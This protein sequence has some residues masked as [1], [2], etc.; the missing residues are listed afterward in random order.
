MAGLECNMIKLKDILK[1]ESE[2]SSY[3]NKAEQG[4][5]RSLKSAKEYTKVKADG[6]T[7]SKAIT[8]GKH[9]W[10]GS[11]RSLSMNKGV[12]H[13]IE[14]AIRYNRGVD[15]SNLKLRSAMRDSIL[16]DLKQ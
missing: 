12:V 11:D 8:G 5:Y 2:T 1:E 16:K 9:S 10:H 7:Y 14:Q 6:V 3:W 15:I 13:Q 4:L